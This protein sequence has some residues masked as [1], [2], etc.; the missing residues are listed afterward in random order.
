MTEYM[1]GAEPLYVEGNSSGCLLLH[2]AGGGTAWDLKEFAQL[3]HAKTGMTVWLPSLSG[4]GTRPEDLFDV[5]LDMWLSDARSGTERLQETCERVFVVGHSA[6]GLLALLMA[7]ERKDIAG[8]VT[9][10]APYDVQT[11]LLHL[12]P[13][14]SRI[15]LLRRAI[16]RTHKSL[17]PE[18]LR[19]EGWVG[20]EWIPTRV[21][22]VMADGL[23][24]LK[25]SL[26]RVDCPALVVQGT[27]DGT[28]TR[29]S[30]ERIFRAITSEKKELHLIEGAHHPMMNEDRHKE[31]LFSVTIE[32]IQ[33]TQR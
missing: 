11:R 29:S 7:S 18:W 33:N 19:K 16:P 24:R 8:L 4:F 2:G 32:F 12:L 10:A 15:P 17:A 25:D 30:A 21:G 23:K 9:W 27:A 31:E 22:L 14:L 26:G 3:L 6:G 1:K 20:Y 5:T 13:V 28:V